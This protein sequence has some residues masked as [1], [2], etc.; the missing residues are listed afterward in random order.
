[1]WSLDRK[2]STAGRLVASWGRLLLEFR[3][4]IALSMFTA[5]NMVVI[6]AYQWYA[7]RVASLGGGT[8]ALFAGLVV[9]QLI[10]AVVTGSLTFVLVPLLAEVHSDA[11]YRVL[12]WTFFVAIGALFL[13]ITVVLAA[14]ADTWVPW[15][16]P[17]FDAVTRAL[18]IRL[19]RVHLL[20]MFFTAMTTV[21]WSV[22]NARH[23]FLWVEGSGALASVLG[24]VVLVGLTPSMGIAAAAWAM[25]LRPVLHLL[26]LL[27]GMGRPTVIDW[28][29]N[30][31]VMARLWRRIR[32]LLLGSTYS[33]S[34][35]LVDRF[36]ASMALPGQL[37]LL[38]L[39]QQ[40]FGAGNQVLTRALSTP[41]LPR[42]AKLASAGEWRS[43]SRLVRS[44]LGP[45]AAITV[46]VLAVIVAVGRPTLGLVFGLPTEDARL[47]WLVLIALGGLWIGGALAQ[48]L[49]TGFYSFG[50]TVIPTRVGV[51]GF[52]LGIVLK[53]LGFKTFGVIGLAL[54][55]STYSMLNAVM[56]F[57]FLTKTL[58]KKGA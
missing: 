51:V 38:H 11:E 6:Y 13:G 52:T 9:P 36:L 37:S 34:D 39:A 25:T 35:Q 53:I 20:G 7:V 4:S 45:I 41:A 54:G 58:R 40:I 28:R 14:L 22:Y 47:L 23:R 17:G 8:D 50:E 18:A 26:M 2:T 21:V 27:P 29:R 12:G 57:V 55:T 48:I 46:G 3:L 56:H 30:R 1:M 5:V 15:T 42:M 33:K 24:L 19:T 43:L 31:E 16:V 32:P 49:T 44:Y 10:L